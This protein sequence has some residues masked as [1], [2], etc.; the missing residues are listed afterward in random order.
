M[1]L[2]YFILFIQLHKFDILKKCFFF[3]F[4]FFFVVVA[5]MICMVVSMLIGA[6]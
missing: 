6:C 2:F 4:G 1:V 3:S 5:K